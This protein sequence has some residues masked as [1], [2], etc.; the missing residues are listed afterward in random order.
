[1]KIKKKLNILVL[2]L[3]LSTV[4]WL[5]Q[6]ASYAEAASVGYSVIPH[7]SEK[8]VDKQN[9]Y[10]NLKLAPGEKENIKVTIKNNSEKE[11]TIDT[12]VDKATT[13]S[14]GV[15]E[16]RNSNK[17]KSTNLKFDL[18]DLVEVSEAQIKL[19][20]NE[21]KDVTFSITQPEEEFDGVIA[22]GINFTQKNTE[23]S[24]NPSSKSN[25]AIRNQYSYSI[26]LVLH[27]KKNLDKHELT[28]GD[29][30]VKQSNGRNNI[31]FPINNETAAFLNKVNIKGD[32]YVKGENKAIFSE[33]LTN[34][35]VAPNSIYE[36][37]IGTNQ[38]ELKPGKYTAKILVESKAQEWSFTK[39]FEISEE[40]SKELNDT[41]VI[42]E[43]D[44][45]LYVLGAAGII[46]LILLIIF[47]IWYVRRKNKEIEELKNIYRAENKN[48][49]VEK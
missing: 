1:M 24:E 37:Q 44:Y 10:Y 41:A 22:G 38:T 19:A 26:A 28:S 14:N 45:S 2:I 36:Y 18:T 7:P 25:M 4:C 34:A 46:L 42:K 47:V 16:Y 6:G 3:T 17:H 27:G 9:T 5:I 31:Y 21:T 13:N 35:Q 40:K 8:Q 33:K 23:D 12:N 15:V 39:D 49:Y 32:V 29:I 30:E 43:N 11:I 20:A 48:Q